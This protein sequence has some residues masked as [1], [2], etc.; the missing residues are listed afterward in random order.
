[1]EGRMS[2]PL[3]FSDDEDTAHF[4]KQL[5]ELDI[6]KLIVRTAPGTVAAD[7]EN[8]AW[9]V[10]SEVRAE[11]GSTDDTYS[12]HPSPDKRPAMILI[13]SDCDNTTKEEPLEQDLEDEDIDEKPDRPVTPGNAMERDECE[14]TPPV[15]KTPRAATSTKRRRILRK[16]R[17]EMAEEVE[18]K[19]WDRNTDPDFIFAG[20]DAELETPTPFWLRSSSRRRA[21]V[22][23]RNLDW[24]SEANDRSRLVCSTEHKRVSRTA[25]LVIDESEE[26]REMARLTREAEREERRKG[27]ARKRKRTQQTVASLSSSSTTVPESAFSISD[28]ESLAMIAKRVKV[29]EDQE[30]ED[31]DYRSRTKMK[32]GE[33]RERSRRNRER[34]EGG[35]ESSSTTT[36]TSSAFSVSDDESLATIRRRI[37]VEDTQEEEEDE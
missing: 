31:E 28:D 16:I 1:A 29:E 33:T 15:M 21:R 35:A 34:R 20:E 8:L 24:S 37:K 19:G 13:E 17:K 27:A 23:Y 30:E 14:L 25:A 12:F 9:R 26:E 11:T 36:V 10:D 3:I 5:Q 18:S 6:S 7:K 4:S 32:K 2:Q 22:T